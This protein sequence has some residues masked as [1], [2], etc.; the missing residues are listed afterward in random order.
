MHRVRITVG[1][2]RVD[3]L[4]EAR[5]DIDVDGAT[6]VSFDGDETR[7]EGGSD[8]CT[9]R[10]PDGT[11]VVLGSGSGDVRL[12][13]RLGAVRVTT[14]SADI[15][16][17]DAASV[18]ARSRSGKLEVERS[19][20]TVRMRSHSA[21]VRIGRA[22]GETRIA[23]VSGLVRVDAAAARVSAKTVSGDIRVEVDGPG[24]VA[25]ETVSGK[26][27]VTLPAGARPDVHH[28]SMSGKLRLGLERGHDLDVTTRTISGD[29]S[30][31]PA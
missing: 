28:R 8:A 19:R 27:D 31:E 18:D 2:G 6:Q 4:A 14:D 22:E 29:V 21:S 13:G 3:V 30:V 11:D 7:I 16:I 5:T 9:V 17:E 15:G 10:V 1:S 24:P 25:A 26:I 12:A 23:S 20:G